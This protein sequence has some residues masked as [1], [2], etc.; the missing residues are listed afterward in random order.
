MG[1]Q[2]AA[3]VCADDALDAA[4]GQLD[5]LVVRLV[6]FFAGQGEVSGGAGDGQRVGGGS[7]SA[8]GSSGWC[9]GLSGWA[10]ELELVIARVVR[11]RWHHLDGWSEST[12]ALRTIDVSAGQTDTHSAAVRS[13]SFASSAQIRRQK[14]ELA[15]RGRGGGEATKGWPR[16]TAVCQ[17]AC[18]SEPAT[19]A[20]SNT[21]LPFEPPLNCQL[22]VCRLPS[23]SSF[24][25]LRILAARL[26]CDVRSSM[27]HPA[28]PTSLPI[29]ASTRQALHIFI[30]A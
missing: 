13:R 6:H 22:P 17:S 16:W 24:P 20:H 10:A 28:L 27:R 26:A 18:L 4:G 3:L 1:V 9:G 2:R 12:C 21:T 23:P 7:G 19:P 5:R 8:C 25:P 15:A 30:A 29:S 14:A 11:A